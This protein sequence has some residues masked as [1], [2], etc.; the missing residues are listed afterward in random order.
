ML[1]HWGPQCSWQCTSFGTLPTS[2]QTVPRAELL[3]AT[4][5]LVEFMGI[6]GLQRLC[7]YSDSKYFVYHAHKGHGSGLDGDNCDLWNDWWEAHQKAGISVVVAKVKAH[8]TAAGLAGPD[9][10]T[11]MRGNFMA[12]TL[13]GLGASRDGWPTFYHGGSRPEARRCF[14]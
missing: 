14:G 6:P 4:R 8:L 1:D 13:A 11:S 2:D 10:I 12:D 9:S 7:I 5:A 3:A